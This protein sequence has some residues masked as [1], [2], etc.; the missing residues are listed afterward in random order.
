MSGPLGSS[1]FLYGTP[2]T[3]GQ[4]LRFEDEDV[5]YLSKTFASAGTRTKYTISLWTKLGNRGTWKYLFAAGTSSNGGQRGYLVID[6]SD[7][8]YFQIGDSSANTSRYYITDAV[9]RDP[10]A[11]YHIVLAVDTTRANSHNSTAGTNRVELYVNGDFVSFGST[12]NA[13]G[14]N[15]ANSVI[16]N[17]TTH[18]IGADEYGKSS[19]TNV[20]DGY[21]A[22][23]SFI[24][25]TALTPTSFGEYDDTLWRSKS[26][27]DITG[28]LTFGTNGF[29]LPFKQTTEAEGFSTV[30]Y[31]GTSAENHIEGVGFE[32]DLVWLKGR[33]EADSHVLTD[34]VR[35]VGKTLKSDSTDAETNSPD[36]LAS[37]DSNG[38]TTGTNDRVGGNNDT[39]VGWCWDA[40]TGSA[41][42]NTDGTITST[43]KANTAKGF[44]IISFVGNATAGATVG[45]GLTSTPEMVIS[46][47]RDDSNNWLVYHKDLDASN[48]EQKR[49]FLNLNSAISDST[50]PWNDTAPTSSLLTLGTSGYTNGSSDDMIMY[51]FHSVSGY[52][53]FGSYSG[54]GSAGN[55]VTLGFEPALV[56]V[57]RTDNT[58]DWAILDNTRDVDTAKDSRLR[59]NSSAIESTVDGLRFSSTGFSF[60]DGSYN[61]SGSTWIYMAFADTR[62]A[63]FFGDTSGNGN[64]WTPNGINNT[65]VVPDSPVS[66]G[67]FAV[68]NELSN[69][70]SVSLKE[71]SLEFTA[72]TASRNVQGTMAVSSGKWYF[73]A[74]M[75]SG[76]SAANGYNVGV[77]TAGCANITT[78]PSAASG[79]IPSGEAL[80][81]VD[82]RQYFYS[83]DGG[84][85]TATSN[86]TAFVAG[87]IIGVALDLDSATQ[88]VS[89]YKNGT[90][91][92]SAQTLAHQD[93]TWLP[94]LYSASFT[95]TPRIMNFGQDSSFANNETPQ[96]NTDDNGVGD[97]YYAPPSGGFL[98]LTTGNLPAATI[99][100]P[101]DYFNTVLYTG[102]SST[103][104]ITV[105]FQPDWTWIKLR[106]GAS[107]HRLVDSVRGVTKYLDVSG[108]AVETTETDR[109]TSFDSDGFTLGN[110]ATVN[111]GFNYVAWNWLAGGTAV[112]NTDGDISSQVSVNNDVGFSI[113]S[114]TSNGSNSDGVGHGLASKPELII[115][116]DRSGTGNW[117]LWTT[118]IDGTNDVVFWNLSTSGQNVP[119]QYGSP[120][121]TT[122]S[123]YGYANGETIIAYCFHSVEGFSKIGTYESNNSTDGRFV[124]TGFAPAWV[125]TKDFDRASMVWGMFDNK[126]ETFNVRENMMTTTTAAEP[127]ATQSDIDFVSNGFKFRNGSTSWNN[128]LTETYFYWAFA[129]AP[130]KKSNA[131]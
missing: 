97:F 5:A 34:S 75:L 101:D 116:K 41:A 37:F 85:N 62:D 76:G 82:S 18:Y 88:T 13:V 19:S 33:N 104:S 49:I 57:K 105:G 92:G 22:N 26:D 81:A 14:L 86:S 111:G 89:F 53:K 95:N 6:G 129:E 23:F 48:P 98:A 125:Q 30:T 123:N 36:D 66:G 78:N 93:D 52:S 72:D 108:T 73:E 127:Y 83:N 59:P 31:I 84:S 124:F 24:D 25:G 55:A 68:L 28:N 130:F 121:A 2:A 58:S 131:K 16:N 109:V 29:Y 70:D 7:Q 100:T 47:N 113:V 21:I 79:G 117:I 80:N 71:G 42:S 38:F 10:S 32:P 63:T 96:G 64:N 39:M 60:A 56:M 99:T 1:Q 40:G 27:A 67:N 69:S 8:I 15:Y 103:Q 51:A 87:D 94:H 118:L 17:N 35:G 61:N 46:K 106:N 107:G 102:N 77:A 3:G 11:W 4:S 9:Y 110:S 54:T 90:I 119:A 114:W 74:R 44:S 122:I 115:Y 20:W 120:T 45:H 65:D 128:Y 126:R 12:T 112:A 43:V 50:T 91:I